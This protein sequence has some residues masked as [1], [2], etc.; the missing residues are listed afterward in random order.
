MLFGRRSESAEG[1][2]HL[3]L[4]ILK[5]PPEDALILLVSVKAQAEVVVVYDYMQ[6][7]LKNNIL[8]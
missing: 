1:L 7:F 4:I 8:I 6:G 5:E 3:T 2:D